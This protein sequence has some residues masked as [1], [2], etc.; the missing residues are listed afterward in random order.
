MPFLHFFFI[1]INYNFVKILHSASH[2]SYKFFSSRK[3]IIQIA[4]MNN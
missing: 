4:S 3:F 2:I 1:S